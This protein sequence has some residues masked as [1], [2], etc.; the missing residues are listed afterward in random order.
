LSDAEAGR[1]RGREAEKSSREKRTSR[2]FAT[3]PDLVRRGVGANLLARCFRD[4]RH[5]SIR[6]LIVFSTLGAEQFYEAFGFERIEPIEV[7]M[8]QSLMFPAILMSRELA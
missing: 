8:G 7:P 5:H 2:H 6:K 1:R 4:A 3:H